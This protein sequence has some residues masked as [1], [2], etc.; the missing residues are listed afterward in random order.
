MAGMTR[1]RH[2]ALLLALPPLLL[3]AA[4]AAARPLDG[5]PHGDEVVPLDP[6]DFTTRID[7]PYLPMPPGLRTV[8]RETDPQGG[9]QRNVVTVTRRTKRLADGIAA[10]V[11]RDVVTERGGVVE[12]TEDFY[13]QDR[14]GTVWYLGEDTTAYEPG[15]PPSKEGSFEAGVDGA[16]GGVV[17]PAH[18][19]AGM[20]YRQ[21]SLPG[22]AEDRAAIVRV[23][24]QAGTPY[25]H[26]RRVVMT[27][28]HSPLEP[29][30]VEW[31]FYARG[32][33]VVLAVSTSG[34]ADREELVRVRR[35]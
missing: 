29:R 1:H 33:G 14:D 2:R 32:I 10:R 31:K 15:R 12:R 21:E 23:R 25:G 34:E 35:P 22:H 24:E 18:P 7:N 26:F 11:V 20:H 5:L 3:A 27:R 17:M 6:A 8:F 9:R 19:R 13:A 16:Q 4:P 30:V 28:E